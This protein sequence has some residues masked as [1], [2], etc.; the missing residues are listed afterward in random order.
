MKTTLIRW[1]NI[2]EHGPLWY[3]HHKLRKQIFVDEAGWDIPHSEEVEW[4]QYDTPLTTYVITH[5]GDRVL[6]ATRILPCSFAARGQSYMIRYATLGRLDSIPETILD[7]PART[8]KNDYEIT[9][10]T[11]DMSLPRDERTEALRVCAVESVHFLNAVGAEHGLILM[12]PGFAGWFRRI[13]I[14]VRRVGPVTE[15]ARGERFCVMEGRAPFWLE[16][17]EPGR[18]AA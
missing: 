2:H 15:N 14:G 17:K 16:A 8:G 12:P 3:N 10:F 6:A 4:D 1:S 9:R 5:A 13:G 11:T 18:E 7:R